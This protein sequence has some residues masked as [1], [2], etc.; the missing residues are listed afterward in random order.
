[1]KKLFPWILVVIA[2]AGI[3]FG[4]W[5]YQ[6]AHATPDVGWKTAPIEK[7]RIAARVTASGTLQATVTVQVG[8]QVSGRIAKLNAD[9]N[10]TVKKGELIA[11]MDP[12]LFI[13]TVEREKA[14]FAAAKAGVVRAEAQQRDAEL[15][16]KRIKSLNEQSLA[17]AAELQTAETNLSVN[18]AATEVA[19]ATLQQATAALRQAEVNLS[20]TDIVSPIDGVVI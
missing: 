15:N 14:N 20:Y 5:R 17:S 9:Y 7:K 8:A 11:K 1:M 16:Q 6:K 2:V 12:Q 4:A 10:S 3:A 19:R 18:T 13:A